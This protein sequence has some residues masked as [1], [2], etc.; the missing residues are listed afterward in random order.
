MVREPMGYLEDTSSKKEKTLVDPS[1]KG[2]WD[3]KAIV[4]GS[5]S[6]APAVYTTAVLNIHKIYNT[7]I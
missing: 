5:N 2:N 6:A 4:L 3:G 7:A 1:S